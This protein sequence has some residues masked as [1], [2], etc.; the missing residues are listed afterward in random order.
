MSHIITVDHLS[1]QVTQTEP[2]DVAA[3]FQMMSETLKTVGRGLKSN[4]S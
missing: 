2:V 3:H 4:V 1:L